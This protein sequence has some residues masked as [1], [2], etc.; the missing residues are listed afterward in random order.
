MELVISEL[1]HKDED[2]HPTGRLDIRPTMNLHLIAS[3]L[4]RLVTDMVSTQK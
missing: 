2:Q 3:A 1:W 4:R